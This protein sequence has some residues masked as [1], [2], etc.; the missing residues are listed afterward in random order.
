M[1]ADSAPLAAEFPTPSRDQWLTLVERTL[2]GDTFERR[3]VSSTYDGLRI[4][5]LY[6]A[7]DGTEASG[8]TLTLRPSSG[9]EPSRPWDLR[10]AIDHPDPAAANRQVLEDLENG[11]ASVLL[12]LDPSGRDGVSVGG[13]DDLARVLSG[14]LLDLAPVALEAGLQGPQAADALAVLAKGAPAAPLAFH[15]DPLSVLAETGAT[16]GPVEAHLISAA[17]TAARHAPAYPKASLFLASGRVVHEAGGSDAQELGFMTAA[18]LTYAK[19]MHR[20]GV[21]IA[22]AFA[23]ITLGLSADA[24]YFT[25]IAKLRAARAIWARLTAACEV[26]APVRIEARASRRMLSR[27]DP[28]VNLLRLTAAGFAAGVGGADA[29]ILEPFT[30]PLGRPTAFARRQARNAQLVLMEEAHIGRV[31]DPAGGSW[32]LE[33]LTDDLA[34]AGW[35]VFREIEQ[36]GGPIAALESGFIAER[37]GEVRLRRE[38]DVAKRKL[39]LVGVSEFPNLGEP[40]VATDPVDPEPFAR[41]LDLRLPG[42]DGHCPPLR[43]SRLSEPFERLRARATAIEPAPRAWLATLG[44]VSDYAARAGFAQALLATGGIASDA[45]AAADAPVQ[46]RLAVICSSDERYAE[47]AVEAARALKAKGASQVWLAGRPG[48][49]EAELTTAGVDGFLSAGMDAVEA[50]ERMLPVYEPNSEETGR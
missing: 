47:G 8:P 13:Q 21:P 4:Q 16:P 28:W 30:R 26:E 15:L 50:L 46:T 31:A 14:V 9:A 3:L 36:R 37:V 33:R 22:E 40:A 23:R 44:S 12:R 11:A 43:A 45:G 20:A 41:A 38:A 34:R 32:Y 6:A 10:T 25:A 1:S 19:A 18:A 35:A 29:V 42:P 48:E 7:E 27:A 24:D 5:P 39:G 2:K 49:L 17:Q